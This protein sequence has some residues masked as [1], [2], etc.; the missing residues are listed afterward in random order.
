[1]NFKG[2]YDEIDNNFGQVSHCNKKKQLMMKCLEKNIFK[3]ETY[4]ISN[5]HSIKNVKF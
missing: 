3:K 5:Y 4:R 1:M 2:T